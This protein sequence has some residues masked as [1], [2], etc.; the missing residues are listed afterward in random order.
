[1]YR[2]Q[3]VLLFIF[4]VILSPLYSKEHVSA[5]NL[6]QQA[7]TTTSTLTTASDY[8]LQLFAN[9]RFISIGDTINITFSVYDVNYTLI[10]TVVVSFDFDTTHFTKLSTNKMTSFSLVINASYSQ[11]TL[12][13]SI[14][15]DQQTVTF[16][17]VNQQLTCSSS[18]LAGTLAVS[19]LQVFEDFNTT[20][21]LS[22]TSDM[23]WFEPNDQ[24]LVYI[25]Q[26]QLVT[27]YSIIN[28]SYYGSDIGYK[29]NHSL[30]ITVPIFDPG[31]F[32]FHFYYY[33]P[34]YKNLNVS[35]QVTI[36]SSA[37][38]YSLTNRSVDRLNINETAHDYITYQFDISTANL[39]YNY[40]ISNSN[41]IVYSST[42]SVANVLLRLP[43][44]VKFYYDV[45]TYYLNLELTKN[46]IILYTKLVQITVYDNIVTDLSF[47]N[48]LTDNQLSINCKLNTYIEDTLVNIPTNV[49]ILNVQTNETLTHVSVYNANYFILS[50]PNASSIPNELKVVTQSIDPLYKGSVAYYPI[51]YREEV[52][53]TTNY[54]QAIQV[55]RLE[56]LQL[57]VQ[58][59]T[60]KTNQSVTNGLVDMVID[61]SIIQEVN[62]SFSN[63]ISDIVPIDYSV[64]K[65]TLQLNYLG[66][67]S[68]RPVTISYD[69]YVYSNVHFDQVTVNNTF[70]N[71]STPILVS[72][73]VKD[74][75]NTGVL[76]RV[77]IRDSNNTIIDQTVT[78]TD[79]KF[80]FIIK[81]TNILGYY[82]YKLRADTVN[83]YKTAEYQ[84]NL[85]QNNAFAVIINANETMKLATIT[86]KG[87]I[88]GEYQLSYYTDTSKPFNIS[89]LDLNSNG[90]LT[91]TFLTPNVLGP[92][93]FNVTNIKD[94]SQTWVQKYI[95]YKKPVIM[96]QQLNDAYVGEK[97]NVSINADMTYNLFFN[98]KLVTDQNTYINNSVV[99]LEVKT[100]G[101]N[102]LKLVFQSQYLTEQQVTQEIFV[103][104]Q[105]HLVQNIPAKINENT[106]ITVYFQVVNNMNVPPG[107]VQIQFMYKGT[108]LFTEKTDN[109]GSLQ[110]YI[111]IND[112]LNKYNFRIVGNKDQYIN[113]EDFPVEAILIRTLTV[114]SNI[115]TLNFNDLTGTAV[116]FTVLYKN[117]G[118][119]APLVNMTIEIINEK[120]EKET[121]TAETSNTGMFTIQI[122]RP[123]GKYILTIL[124]TDPNYIMS[125]V[126]YYFKVEGFNVVN[127]PF[128][129][130]TLLMSGA[131]ILVI[132]RKKALK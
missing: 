20:F 79:G 99:S 97:V 80:S 46:N 68:L 116:I 125:K 102:I 33:S 54:N 90:E 30:F 104:E 117:T 123:V 76:T 96:I 78:T 131:G 13:S 52:T 60:T 103:Y 113:Q 8:H 65:H 70:T 129:I 132:V 58:V 3:L 66:T 89:V 59:T 31:I 64:G 69:L 41:T 37:I 120:Q 112:D 115:N 25:D 26:L 5:I 21:K 48:E 29:W 85:L 28:S 15:S 38:G 83:Y 34:H 100:K 19:Q 47:N 127:N 32:T 45:G 35:K 72:G 92:I 56:Q 39:Q 109:K 101:I 40:Y 82:N 55:E 36:T 105:V 81:N 23:Q 16:Y 6:V 130:P 2:K 93:Y 7:N 18:C 9:K 86:V 74:E 22:I 51:Y 122:E 98:D 71:P 11:V 10:P 95:L 94:P 110:T 126:V 14:S 12:Q 107:I 4:L 49:T 1:M 77:S 84:F 67:A 24:L 91:T 88:Y 62:L 17:N 111:T 50:F 73:Y 121:L 108:V 114:S 75:N 57:Q 128:V 44:A 124:T 27:Y 87:D 118:Q 53:I 42:G 61:G 63:I 43:I 106:N 119:P